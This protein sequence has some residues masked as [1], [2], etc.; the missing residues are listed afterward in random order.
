[1]IGVPLGT[2]VAGGN[3]KSS[4]QVRVT[5]IPCPQEFPNIATITYD[6]EFETGVTSTVTSTSNTCTVEY[7]TLSFL[8][9]FKDGILE[10]PSQKPDIESIVSLDINLL[11][12]DYEII[13]SPVGTSSSKQNLT[14]KK[15]LIHFK[16]CIMVTYIATDSEQSVHSAEY[17][18]GKCEYIVLPN[19]D[20]YDCLI[21]LTHEVED[22]FYSQLNSRNVFYN[23]TYIIESG[24]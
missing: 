14:G 7:K 17:E 13:D 16:L 1:M 24:I 11:F 20:N 19:V 9:C 15:L 12:Q 2:I 5:N 6:A 18:L 10:I 21:N 8:Q 4:F 23:I 3:A 22:V